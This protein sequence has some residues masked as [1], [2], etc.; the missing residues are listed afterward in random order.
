[1]FVYLFSNKYLTY[2]SLPQDEVEPG[3]GS[4]GSGF[5]IHPVAEKLD[6]LMVVFLAYIRDVCLPKGEHEPWA[7]DHAHTDIRAHNDL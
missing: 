6:S 2:F 4:S 1:L 3:H 7:L 5:T